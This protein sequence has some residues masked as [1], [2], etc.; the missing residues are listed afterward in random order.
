MITELLI[1]DYAL[2]SHLH[3]Q[4]GQ[5]FSV[6]TG[7]TG[8]GKSIILGAISLLLGGRADLKAIKQGAQKC[9][10]EA[11]F[12]LEGYQMEDFF[13]QNEI[14][15]DAEDC[16][17]RRELLATGKSRAFINDTPAP[18]SLLR[19]LGYRLVDIHS[20]HQNLLLGKQD[21]QLQVVD[22]IAQDAQQLASYRDSF[23]RLQDARRQLS[24]L[25]QQIEQNRQNQD[26]LQFQ[27]DELAAARLTAGEQEELEQA[28]QRMEHAED[29]KRALYTADE[30]L[31]AEENGVVTHLRQAAQAL[32][33]I[34]QVMPEAE[35]MV[36][37][38]NSAH[39]DMKD[40][41]ADVS[42]LLEDI[43]FDPAEL[44]R[45]TERLDRIYTLQKKHQADSV[46]ALL[47][48]QA[49]IEEQLSQ[50]ENSSEAVAQLEQQVAQTEADCR[51]QAKALTALRTKA[52]GLIEQ[53]TRQRL[54]PLGM[55]KVRFSVSISPKEL[56]DDG[57]DRVAML[58]SA[59]T[60]SPLQP[61]AE[62]A[63][64]GE[65]ARVMLALKAMISGAVRLPT[66]IFDEIDTG[67]SGRV[68]ECMG[69]IMKEMGNEGRQ[70][71]SIT[72]LPQIAALGSRHYRVYKEETAQGTQTHMVE[73][74]PGERVTEIAQ[75]LSGSELT[76]AAIENAKTLI[77]RNK[78]V[79]SEE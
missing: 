12:R 58:F 32:A 50:L 68:A 17:V 70:V 52:A 22:I 39:I 35:E 72:H 20:Q 40:L 14:D 30:A 77:Q 48:K 15:Y 10:I 8:A 31:S 11:H 23:A 57:A 69:A 61:V 41:A 36:S 7:E 65:I 62:V 54:V 42:A 13:R 56:A 76:D 44:D 19:D 16:I 43:D 2:I 33:G 4:L 74:Q 25:Q 51:R 45:L 37:R 55:P 6:I 47:E 34:A 21:F 59:N 24:L 53:Q 79:K 63:S 26:F 60:S 5:G 28:T 67:V 64:G 46:E 66:I 3:I 9:I 18:L 78:G 49:R 71:V 29:I 73:L 1:R 27:F 75:M 38:L